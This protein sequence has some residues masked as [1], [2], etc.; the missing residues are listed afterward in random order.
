MNLPRKEKNM[1]RDDVIR[2]LETTLDKIKDY[3]VPDGMSDDSCFDVII[4]I[5]SAI[6]KAKGAEDD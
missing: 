1:T 6:D 3:G 4:L 5:E 2:E